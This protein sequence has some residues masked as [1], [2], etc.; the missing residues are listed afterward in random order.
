M[1]NENIKTIIE[2]KK[3]VET[4]QELKDEYKNKEIER[5]FI[6]DHN[7]SHANSFQQMIS[8]VLISENKI[9]DNNRK[10]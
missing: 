6:N 1:V 7:I 9:N 4:V 2:N 5:K 3:P 10:I 8:N